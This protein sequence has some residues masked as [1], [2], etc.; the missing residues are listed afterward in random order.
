MIAA[1]AA[2]L[3]RAR[4]L[5]TPQ[6]RVPLLVAG[7]LGLAGLGIGPVVTGAVSGVVLVAVAA[8]VV[9][10]ALPS[11]LIYSRRAPSPY[12][13]RAADILDIIAIMALIPLACAV[14]GV[15]DDIRGLFASIGG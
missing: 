4:L 9:A 15:F 6:Q 1:I 5:P 11:A 3:L 14:I 2:L 10:V 13:G 12:L 8:V 7:L